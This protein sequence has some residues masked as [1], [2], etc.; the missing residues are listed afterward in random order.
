MSGTC[1]VQVPVRALVEFSVFAGDITPVSRA[2]ME[3]GS[4][5]HRAR[6]RIS[7]ARSEV[8]VCW[9]GDLHGLSFRISGRI[10]LLDETVVPP[11]IEEIKLLRGDPVS[12]PLPAHRA[13]ALVYAY[14]LAAQRE[15]NRVAIRVAYADESGSVRC[16]FG[17]AHER[18]T[19]EAFF[20]DLLEPYA[21]WQRR[22]M[23]TRMA[24]D[25]SIKALPFPYPRYRP[26]QR[27]LAAQ[28]Y[29]AIVRGKKLFASVPTGAGKSAA[30]LYPAVKALGEGISRQVFYLTART[31]AR[32]AALAELARMRAQGLFL[33]ALTLSARE[34]V[35]PQD[36]VR[37]DP[38]WCPRAKGHYDRQRAALYEALTMPAW[39]TQDILNLAE[40]H[41]LCPFELSLALCE[42]ADI[43]VCD[44]NYAYDPK[45]Y[46][47]RVFQHPAQVTLLIDEAHNLPSRA[48]DMLSG[49]LDS[50]R[51][52]AFRREDGRR[53][54][55]TTRVYRAATACI[56]ALRRLQTDEAALPEPLLRAAETLADALAEP[57]TP[58]RDGGLFA[59]LLSFL[60]AARRM[61]E[62]PDDYRLLVSHAGAGVRSRVLCLNITRYLRNAN[63]RAQGA[64]FFSAT[65]SPLDSMR[66]LLG[67]DE[68]DACFELPSPFPP[69]HLLVLSVGVN[70]RYAARSDT[71]A[72]IARA[73]HGLFSGRPGKCIAFFPSYAYLRMVAETLQQRWPKLPLLLQHGGMDEAARDSFLRAFTGTDAPVLALCVLGGVFSE[74]I[75]LPGHALIAVCVVGVGLPQ[76]NTEQEALLEHFD[77]L[78]G[79]GFGYAYRY[80]GMHKVLQASGR[81]I[82][83]EHD[84]GV[85]LLLDDRYGTAAFSR[86]LPAHFRV[87]ELRDVGDVEAS[88]RAFW[89]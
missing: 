20:F 79:D 48:R 49:E 29:T 58:W 19:L 21:V 46:L 64:V 67:G 43:V 57:G 56:R 27:A 28:V 25:A 84:R 69:E 87:R 60:L 11:C 65:L 23:D 88:V 7:G 26:G 38:M 55:R 72:E 14:L 75:D 82:R 45:V 74:G 52:S 89:A 16:S 8:P 24:R 83:S 50:A 17:E 77:R 40:R 68:E 5:A 62:A 35:C 6:Q 53:F 47:R 37:C 70:T 66:S 78:F 9:Q 18:N 12:E 36:T 30:V 15:L 3:A 39:D 59:D 33:H 63:A 34:K 32:R 80:P 42:A 22:L 81:V 2:D 54:G 1:P 71:A 10:D 13:Q 44:Y 86:L 85:V 31:T 76:I 41:A 61:Q 4:R 51:L 73:I